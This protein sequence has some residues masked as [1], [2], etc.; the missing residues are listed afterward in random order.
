MNSNRAVKANGFVP[1]Y[2]CERIDALP[3]QIPRCQHDSD[4][5]SPPRQFGDP[6]S[7]C[8]TSVAPVLKFNFRPMYL[9]FTHITAVVHA[10]LHIGIPQRAA[11]RWHQW[12]QRKADEC[13]ARGR[14]AR[15]E[16]TGCS[17]RI[18]E[19][20][21][22]CSEATQRRSVIR[23]LYLSD[24]TYRLNTTLRDTEG[25]R[26][27]PSSQTRTALWLDSHDTDGPP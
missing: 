22:L 12:P 5:H 24:R 10:V 8:I 4:T 25:G 9:S 2:R 6:P 17:I 1:V 13:G 16:G 27:W 15:R 20:D 7:P 21:R 26:P 3:T 14:Y 11:M 23:R 19:Y 18:P